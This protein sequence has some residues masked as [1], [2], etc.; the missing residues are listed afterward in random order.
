SEVLENLRAAYQILKRNVIRTL[1]TQ[2]GAEAQLNYQ[3]NEAL[4]FFSA[5]DRATIPPDEFATL[6]RSITAMMD[7]LNEAR[8]QSSD[9]PT[10]S[11]LVVTARTHTGGRPRV[12]IDPAFLSH[13]LTLR[14][15]SGLQGIFNVS[16]RTIRR[17]ALEYGLVQ[18]GQPVYRDVPQLDG[19]VARTYTSTSAPVSSLTDDELDF[20]LTSILQIF[21]NFGRR[22]IKGRLQAAGHRVP[23]ERIAASYLR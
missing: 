7:S 11:R 20:F 8:H 15:P 19:T 22:M 17:R 5:A 10:S 23:R 14:G 16:A 9:P 13:A 6:E 21:P 18:P 12:E 4:Q 1:R 2:R 3:V